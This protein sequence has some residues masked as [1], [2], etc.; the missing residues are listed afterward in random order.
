MPL[1]T[2][3]HLGRQE[4]AV[5]ESGIQVRSD[6]PIAP[7]NKQFWYNETQNKM[8]YF[9]G[10]SKYVIVEGGIGASVEIPVSTIVD[11]AT[12][13]SFFKA[14]TSDYSIASID[15]FREG[16]IGYIKFSNANNNVAEVTA[17]TMP[18]PTSFANG[19]YFLINGAD[20]LVQNYVWINF[21]GLG[22]DPLVAGKTGIEVASSAGL[23]EV[24]E[25]TFPSASS[26]TSGQHFL[27]YNANDATAFYVWFNKDGAGGDPLIGGKTGIQVPILGTDTA[28]IVAEKAKD[29]I[30]LNASFGATFSS[31]IT[32]VTNASIGVCTDASNVDVAGLTV[33]ITQQGKASDTPTQLAIAVAAALDAQPEY[34]V[35]VPST[36]TL[37]VTNSQAGFCT[38]AVDG[39]IGG[40][41]SVNVTQQ[42][43]G[44]VYVTMP[45]EVTINTG[46]DFWVNGQTE[47]MFTMFNSD[48]I[49]Y[50]SAKEYAI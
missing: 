32:T 45:S 15:N 16:L 4:E 26:I 33:N 40:T 34:S 31:N 3:T 10:V 18:S 23:P 42:G 17:I 50:A 41:F 27:L 24:T 46:E 43:S 47:K 29:A 14:I 44:R 8:K 39:N 20:D 7:V 13:R 6:D 28:T 12:S 2:R 1:S 19:S 30:D 36:N 9:D 49:I 11:F 21:D 22:T 25:F 38:D 35:P 5:E 48:G 37:T